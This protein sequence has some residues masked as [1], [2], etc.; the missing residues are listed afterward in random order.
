MA[1][2]ME[3]LLANMFYTHGVGCF[4]DGVVVCFTVSLKAMQVVDWYSLVS[5]FPL[6]P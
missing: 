3:M 2:G 4:L 6:A 1:H 5:V